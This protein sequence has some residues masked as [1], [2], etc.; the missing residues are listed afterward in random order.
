M[1]KENVVDTHD[2]ILFRFEKKG[3]LAICGNINVGDIILNE[4]N[5]LQKDKHSMFQLT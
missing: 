5:Q 3:H 4:L 2:G 1:D